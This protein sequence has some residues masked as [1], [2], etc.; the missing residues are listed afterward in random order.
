[1]SRAS[2]FCGV[3]REGRGAPI[4]RQRTVGASGI[5]WDGWRDEMAVGRGTI[6]WRRLVEKGAARLLE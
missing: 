6:I 4:S 2:A 5:K 1:M 3:Y